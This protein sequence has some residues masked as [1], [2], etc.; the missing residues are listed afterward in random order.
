MRSEKTV[1]QGVKN[2]AK[3]VISNVESDKSTT[4]QNDVQF[5]VP[6]AEM[7]I[8][9]NAKYKVRIRT[10]L[11]RTVLHP[12]TCLVDT[13]SGEKLINEHYLK[14]QWKVASSVSN[15]QMEGRQQKR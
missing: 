6:P 1:A 2:D 12:T 4:A 9:T 7:G 13:R 14:L 11:K 10:S 8:L 5:E 3:F 15:H